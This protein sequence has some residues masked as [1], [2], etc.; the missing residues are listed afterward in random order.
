MKLNNNFTKIDGTLE[1]WGGNIKKRTG[2]LD[3]CILIIDIVY[4]L[5]F[6]TN[7]IPL[8]FQ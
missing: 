8:K 6:S 2:Q 4:I 1:I 7:E 5:K 3:T